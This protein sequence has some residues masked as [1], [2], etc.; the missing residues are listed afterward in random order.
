MAGEQFV[1][2]TYRGLELGKRLRLSPLGP[3]SAHVEH[4]TP[5]PVGTELVITSE[6]GPGIPVRVMEVHEPVAGADH[7]PGMRVIMIESGAA[8]GAGWQELGGQAGP[9]SAGEAPSGSGE[10]PPPARDTDGQDVRGEADTPVLDAHVLNETPVHEA[11]AQGEA[12]T[13]EHADTEGE[14]Q[15]SE[16]G[17]GEALAADQAGSV[18]GEAL[19]ATFY[20]A[21]QGEPSALAGSAEAASV[22]AAA[23]ETAPAVAASGVEEPSGVEDQS[24]A[25]DQPA[26]ED[27]SDFE[28]PGESERAGTQ[29][30][31]DIA[32]AS[33]KGKKRRG[34]RRNKRR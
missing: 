5:M 29:P 22:E 24:D 23:V 20:E 26:A 21:A 14:R 16:P 32:D 17:Q 12:E 3:G 19:W 2:V 11:Q 27:P 10:E 1:D 6:G 28:D 9:E 25:D 30:Q 15:V 7:V 31:W 8:A 34:R 13:P 33:P 4:S 18:F